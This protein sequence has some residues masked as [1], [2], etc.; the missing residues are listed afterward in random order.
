MIWRALPPTRRTVPLGRCDGDAGRRAMQEFFGGRTVRL[1]RSGTQSL[2]VAMAECRARRGVPDAEVIVPAYGCPDLVSACVEAGVRPRLV[3][4]SAAGWGYDPVALAAAISS[5]TAA[6]VAVN[7][8]GLGD[9]AAQL[10]RVARESGAF[11]IQDSAQ[12]L[13]RKQRTWSGDYVV[14]SFGRGKPMN[15]LRGGALVLPPNTTHVPPEAPVSRGARETLLSSR[16]AAVLFNVASAPAAYVWVA[17]LPGMGLGET[18]YKPPHGI[19]QLPEEA[20][21][22]VGAALN[23]YRERRS[24]DA[25]VWEGAMNSWKGLGVEPLRSADPD[26]PETE[27]LRLPLLARTREMRDA[28]VHELNRIGAGAS[29]MY[30]A[31]L[32]AVSGVPEEVTA[33]GPFPNAR[34]LADRLFTLPTHRGV[35]ASLVAR[36]DAQLRRIAAA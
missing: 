35:R 22:Q 1:Y 6:I 36:V 31:P 28:L 30:A 10:E 27:P 3:D 25:S 16:L 5:R 32:N 15:L 18:R 7:L 14:L 29:P 4:V 26:P 23:A 24:Y 2:A 11:L 20:W 12:H 17:K 19:T 8:L 13:P 21:R 33:Q 9:G 34:A